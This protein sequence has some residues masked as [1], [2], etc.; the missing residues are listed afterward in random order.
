MEGPDL[1]ATPSTLPLPS[2]PDM[3]GEPNGD[4]TPLPK[5]NSTIT[6]KTNAF[7]PGT[8]VSINVETEDA[9]ETTPPQVGPLTLTS[10]ADIQPSITVT[11]DSTGRISFGL[12]LDATTSPGRYTL[13]AEAADIAYTVEVTIEGGP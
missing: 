4:P 6:S 12:Y 7:P 1:T 3:S 13:S 5:P 9:S 10:L 11:A 8:S 2:S